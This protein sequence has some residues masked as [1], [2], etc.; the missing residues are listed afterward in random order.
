M[1]PFKNRLK[2]PEEIELEHKYQQLARIKADLL[3]REQDYNRLKS[4]IRMF[5]QVYEDIL[6]VRIQTLEDLEWQLKGLLGETGRDVSSESLKQSPSYTHFQHT[7]DLLD[8]DE[9]PQDAANLSLKSLYRGVAKAV[10]PR[11][12]SD[13]AP[14]IADV[15]GR[16]VF[17]EQRFSAS[18]ARYYASAVCP[19]ASCIRHCC[20]WATFNAVWQSGQLATWAWRAWACDA[21]SKP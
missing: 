20:F 13:P 5:E 10:L 15:P 14:A 3:G 17:A 12:S 18:A 6:G 11:G 7:T 19:S 8:D 9:A 21:S 4:I 16:R 2:T 1:T